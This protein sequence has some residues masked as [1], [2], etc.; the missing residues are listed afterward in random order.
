MNVVTSL[1]GLVIVSHLSPKGSGRFMFLYAP[2]PKVFYSS[3]VYTSLNLLDM[4]SLLC[5]R[6]LCRCPLTITFLSFRI[7]FS[8]IIKLKLLP[9]DHVNSIG[10]DMLV[11]LHF[12]TL[13]P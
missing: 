4:I 1:L 3:M 13:I 2:L 7:L 5:L 6:H 10:I 8:S 9:C 11:Y 12:N